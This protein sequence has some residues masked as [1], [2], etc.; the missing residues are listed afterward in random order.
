MLGS[1]NNSQGHVGDISR[2]VTNKVK[3]TYGVATD[4]FKESFKTLFGI[5][6]EEGL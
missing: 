2:Y 1:I 6:K 5:N 4:F 3:E